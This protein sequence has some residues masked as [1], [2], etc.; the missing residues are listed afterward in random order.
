MKLNHVLIFYLIIIT[1]FCFSEVPSINEC[2]EYRNNRG[3]DNLSEQTTRAIQVTCSTNNQYKFFVTVDSKK[4]IATIDTIY[5]ITIFHDQLICDLLTSAAMERLKYIRQYGT[6]IY[7]VPE[8]K[9]YSRFE[10]SVGVLQLLH[11]FNAPYS[12][13]I[14]G[15]LHDVSHT[16]FSHVGDYVFKSN[17]PGQSYQDQIHDWYLQASGLEVILNRHGFS[18]KALQEINKTMLDC[19]LPDLCVD[20]LEY[21]LMAGI[22]TGLLSTS[23]VNN[24]LDNVKYIDGRWYFTSIQL[25]KKFACVSLFNTEH[26]WGG[27]VSGLINRWTA[28]MLEYSVTC[29]IIQPSEI[30]FSIDHEIWLRLCASNHPVIAT[31]ITKIKNPERY[32][33]ISNSETCTHRLHSKFRGIDPWIYTT[34]EI[35]E[36]LTQCDQDFSNE[37]VR[38]KELVTRGWYVTVR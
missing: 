15:L 14:A 7:G 17:N 37:Y 9:D 18:S 38:I 35:F 30:N 3:R 4:N 25:A 27:I 10:H 6:F 26:I 29:G 21:N 12:L 22:L 13:Q 23:D 16:I 32:Y 31:F 34:P 20:R 28:D 19:D 8:A 5:G 11:K 33:T 2:Y 24:I 36:R 1:P